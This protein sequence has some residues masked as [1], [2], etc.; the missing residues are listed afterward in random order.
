MLEYIALLAMTDLELGLAQSIQNQ[1][2]RQTVTEYTKLQ[3]M[4]NQL[5]GGQ[6]ASLGAMLG[7]FTGDSLG[8][9]LEFKRGSQSVNQVKLAMSMPGGATWDLAPGQITDDSE[10]AMCQLRGLLAGN[11]KLDAF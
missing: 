5:T 4:M 3:R 10:L 11:G 9:F 8:S 7:A 1:D 6:K 2:E